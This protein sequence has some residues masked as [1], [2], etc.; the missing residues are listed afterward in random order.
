MIQIAAEGGMAVAVAW[1][2]SDGGDLQRLLPIGVKD[3]DANDQVS[4]IVFSRVDSNGMPHFVSRV[5]EDA[6]TNLDGKGCG[7][8][9][10][11]AALVGAALHLEFVSVVSFGQTCSLFHGAY[12]HD[13]V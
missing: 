11:S 13:M 1:A 5:P 8:D 2:R 6:L 9:V 7:A 10:Q 4:V 12:L 3:Q